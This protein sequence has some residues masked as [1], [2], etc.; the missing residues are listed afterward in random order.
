MERSCLAIVIPAYNEENTIKPVITK[1]SKYGDVVVVDDAS[2][3]STYSVAKESAKYV[4]RNH[5]NKGYDGALNAGFRLA[6]EKNYEYVITCDADGQHDTKTIYQYLQILKDGA[7]I[8]IGKRQKLARVAEKI[9]A[10]LSK[11]RYGIDDP[12]C[13][14]K[15]YK[16]L[17]Y[18]ELGSF[19]SYSSIGTELLFYSLHNNYI[20]KQVSINVS[21][22]KDSPRFGNK[23]ISNYKIIR[24]AIITIWKYFF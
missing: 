4:V 20:V 2:T 14:M 18:K 19:D 5:V 23:L 8:V 21:E 6:S 13:G 3:D 15:G 16:L 11:L 10:F 7:D 9:F 12:L 17:I 24:S 1:A 22:R